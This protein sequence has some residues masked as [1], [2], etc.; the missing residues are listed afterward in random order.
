MEEWRADHS[1]VQNFPLP[2]V[3]SQTFM[4]QEEQKENCLTH[5]H[6][7]VHTAF[8]FYSH[9]KSRI[10]YFLVKKKKK[11]KRGEHCSL[12]ECQSQSQCGGMEASSFRF[13]YAV[14]SRSVQ[15]KLHRLFGLGF[16]SYVDSFCH[17]NQFLLHPFDISWLCIRFY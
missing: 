12:L 6:A 9:Q 2:L 7:L 3:C 15:G 4:I 13:C 11:K 16:K 17:F 1:E 10:K 8:S 5:D 14:P